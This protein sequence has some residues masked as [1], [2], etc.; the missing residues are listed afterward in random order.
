MKNPV[1]I[2]GNNYGIVVVLNP[3]IEFQELREDII[4]KFSESK[5]F[6]KD[7][8]MA[9]SF[10]GR[11][12]TT[13]QEKDVL[14]II[15]EYTDMNIICVVDDN[16]EL[17][18]KFKTTMEER[19]MELGDGTGQ[20][21]KGILRSGSYL[22]FENS[23]IIIGDVNIGAKVVSKGNIIVLGSLKGTAH[24]G[25]TGDTNAFVIALD[26]RPSQ[27]RISNSIARSPDKPIKEP[28]SETMIAYLED[29]NIYIEPLNKDILHD[30]KI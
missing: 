2:K 15:S 16:P 14:D 18:D 10:E 29:G 24:A 4:K 6:F 13:E 30:I 27:I 3:D 28:L 7:A 23:A 12:L 17:E 8:N 5:S 22:E 25:A 11:T 20:F 21:Y 26:M 9:I 19:L 1:M